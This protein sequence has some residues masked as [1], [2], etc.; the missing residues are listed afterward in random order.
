MLTALLAPPGLH[1]S[2]NRPVQDNSPLSNLMALLVHLHLL[3]TQL[4]FEA[5][6]IV[7]GNYSLRIKY[8]LP[9]QNK[10]D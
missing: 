3:N 9:E 2:D 5:I 1:H 6:V 4:L 8:F 7:N 10:A